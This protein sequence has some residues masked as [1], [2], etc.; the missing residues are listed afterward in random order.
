MIGQ[1]IFNYE[2]TAL[3]GKGGMGTVYKATDTMLGRD[4]ALKMLH[5]ELTIQSQFLERF[6]KEARVLAQLLHV[7]IAVIYNFLEQENNHFMVM[8]FVEGTNLDELVKKHKT[9]PPQFVVPVFVQALEGLNHAHKK[10]IFHRDIKPAN[11]ML[12]P[13][14]TVKLM[15]F[16]IAKIAGEQKMTQVNK[17]IGTI[18]YMAPELI[19]GQDASA[20]SDIYAMGLTLYEVLTGQLPFEN[21]TDYNM[22]QAILNKKVTPPNKL[23]LSSVNPAIPQALSE[24]VMKAI[25]RKPANRFADARSFQQAL[26]KAFPQYTEINMP[27]LT[28]IVNKPTVAATRLENS[29]A[30]MQTREEAVASKSSTVESL[31]E[32]Y[33]DNKKLYITIALL[34]LFL[35]V[36]L[37]IFKNKS[38]S[39]LA[40]N[41]TDSLQKKDGKSIDVSD[42]SSTEYIQPP[43]K[44]DN[45][46]PPED[47]EGGKITLPVDENN[48][49]KDNSK[50]K[51]PIK[52]IPVKIK[53]LIK[54]VAPVVVQQEEEKKPQPKDIYIRTKVEVELYLQ[55]NLGNS[56]E[57]TDLPVTFTVRNPVVYNGVTII[58]RGTI[59]KGVIKLGRVQTDVDINSTTATNGQHIRLKAQRGHGRRN[60][61]TTNRN[62]TA[63]ILPGV[64]LSY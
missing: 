23:P 46:V 38:N 50:E 55:D 2:I 7:N 19:Q 60:E 44:T 29:L 64:R 18:E 10:N 13:E 31:K 5:P 30:T 37:A 28:P 40:Q 6:K 12:T 16:G 62:Y 49:N 22:M 9:L 3:L 8:E 48:E 1:K 14:G 56:P 33:K 59:A 42:N 45:T 41:N 58:N 26:Q 47:G 21:D 27:S 57:R 35:I 15:D 53:D 39:N 25:E 61:I 54:K 34:L 52:K 36:S 24:I 17:I 63:I 4:V 43:T 51:K 11:L 20:A 32:G